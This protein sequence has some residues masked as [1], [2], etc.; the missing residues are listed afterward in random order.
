MPTSHIRN[1]GHSAKKKAYRTQELNT[2]SD[3]SVSSLPQ[4]TNIRDRWQQAKLKA[5]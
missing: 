5:S 1:C 4:L 2:K 3:K